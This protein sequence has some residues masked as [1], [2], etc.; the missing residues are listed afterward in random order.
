MRDTTDNGNS[1]VAETVVM[2]IDVGSE[3][4]CLTQLEL[5][6]EDLVDD[7]IMNSPSKYCAL[8]PLPACLLKQELEHESLFVSAAPLCF[9]KVS[10]RSL[11]KQTN[12]DKEVLKNY[13]PILVVKQPEYHLYNDGLLDNQ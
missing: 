10:V 13:Q 3:G 11:L 4:Q 6:T 9:E 8:D 2:D 7:V 12:L 1:S 5:F